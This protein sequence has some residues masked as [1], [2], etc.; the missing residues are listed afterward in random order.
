MK[1]YFYHKELGS[2]K[3]TLIPIL[4]VGGLLAGCA[5]IQEGDHITLKNTIYGGYSI[6]DWAKAMK[7]ADK[8]GDKVDVS[9]IDHVD[10]GEEIEVLK[11]SDKYKADQIEY[12]DPDTNEKTD[13][14]V[15]HDDLEAAK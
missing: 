12:T 7:E 3:R 15:S 11:V 4:L 10:K 13:I 14:W 9:N 1:V 2:L 8:V 6:N 5:D